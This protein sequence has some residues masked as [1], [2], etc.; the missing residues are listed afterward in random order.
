MSKFNSEK[1]K[2]LMSEVTALDSKV[3]EV[4]DEIH[5]AVKGKK[6]IIKSD[7]NGQPY[8]SSKKIDER[9]DCGN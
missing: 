3:K 7:H 1:L 8:G 9:E 5:D 6:A 2:T 4:T